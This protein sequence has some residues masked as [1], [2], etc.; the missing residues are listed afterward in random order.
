MRRLKQIGQ[1]HIAAAMGAALAAVG[2]VGLIGFTLFAQI[3]MPGFSTS[4]GKTVRSQGGSS[5]NVIVLPSPSPGGPAGSGAEAPSVADAIAAAAADIVA[6][7]ADTG[8]TV[9]P[10][11][12]DGTGFEP[13]STDD[14]AGP[15]AQGIAPK[16]RSK[17]RGEDGSV[18]AL[19]RANED[20]GQKGRKARTS[21]QGR[22]KGFGEEDGRDK[23]HRVASKP[24][25][26]GGS[27]GHGNAS[28]GA[29]Q[30]HHSRPQA[31]AGKSTGGDSKWSGNSKGKR[32]PKGRGSR[33]SRN[34]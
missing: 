10:T 2:A 23:R 5:S 33:G 21:R 30:R 25:S 16:G 12:I 11:S 24:R 3:A 15:G 19:S 18:N 9:T 31:H 22:S 1:S 32:D 13:E 27:S 6:F 14:T 7:A 20:K 34:H 8:T 26:H 29:K 4:P 28:A 17:G